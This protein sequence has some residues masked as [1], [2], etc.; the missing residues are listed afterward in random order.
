[1]TSGSRHVVSGA[2]SALAWSRYAARAAAAELG[3][4]AETAAQQ[5]WLEHL[6]AQPWDAPRIADA[7]QRERTDAATELAAQTEEQVL[8]RA[9]RRVR[10]HVLL[11][12]IAR[13]LD[14]RASL[15]EV[16]RAMT[17]L[18]ETAVQE[19]LAVLA[20]ALAQR[21]GVPRAPD[22]TPQDLLVVAMGKGGGVELNVSSDLDLVFVYDEEGD[23]DAAGAAKSI[24]NHEFFERLGRALIA[25]LSE[26]TAD[27]FV[28]RVDMRLRPNGDSG[29][30]AVSTAM[31]EEYFIGQGRE[32][33]RFAWLKGRVIS[34]PVFASR[35]QF[36]AQLHSLETEVRP[37]VYRKYLDFGAIA[38]L[39]DL[40]A[41][42][43][44]E[45]GRKNL[46]RDG[47][48]DQH[49][50]NVK[51]GR[52]GIREIEFI[53]Q[54]FQIIRGGRERRL[55]SR[56]TLQTLDV[57]QDLG[58]LAAE[59]CA[60]LAQAYEFLRRL[61]HALQY[62]DDMQTHLLPADAAERER[63]ARMLRLSSAAELTQRFEATRDFVATTFDGVFVDPGTSLLT[64]GRPAVALD[65]A[66]LTERLAELG[67]A[68][69][70]QSAE[71]IQALLAAR[72]VVGSGASRNA[73]QRLVARALEAVAAAAHRPGAGAYA[74]AECSAD[75]LLARFIRLLDVL[76]GRTTY[77]ALLAQ[78]PQAFARVLR[79]L[80]ASRWATEYLLRH[81]ILLDEL[82]D[83][84][85][86]DITNEQRV[87][88]SEWRA[89]LETQLAA[90]H[91]DS[92]REM[93]LVR[94]AHHAQVFRLLVADLDGRLTV[95][96]LADHLSLLADVVL[97]VVLRLIWRALPRRHR[98]APRFA[99]VAY[100]KLG[101]KELGYASDLDLIFLFDDEHPDAAE[102]YALFARKLTIWLTT[103]TSSGILFSV[104]LRL[105]PNGD[106]G[107]LVS[108][109]AAFERYERNDDGHGAWTWEHQALTR[110]RFCAGDVQLGA[111]FEA[112]RN[113]V[114]ARPRDLGRLRQEVIEMRRK[115][116]DGHPNRG[117]L[118]DL[119]HDRGGMVDI[120]FI[121]QFLV[122]AHAHGQPRLLGNLGNIALLN[123]AGELGLIDRALAS[124]VANAYR[125][126]RRIQHRLRLNVEPESPA[127]SKVPAEEMT[128][129]MTA[130]ITAV[131][132]LWRAVF[133]TDAPQ[134]AARR[135]A[136]A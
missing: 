112:L 64:A 93:N 108:S 20:P 47:G 34:A 107:L 5:A 92:E 25:L 89:E 85:L 8:A 50:N 114:L 122:L 65:G 30:L 2:H 26:L 97:D 110:A 118:F 54:T 22:G 32:W 39:R 96:R 106:A 76:A 123:I 70:A 27:G 3:A 75:E 61:E 68:A 49:E 38:A 56:S 7:L 59:T 66:A 126:Y 60:R 51:L 86:T 23:T 104:D 13:D 124:T 77:L 90:L 45:T 58:L 14:G 29:P 46:R 10:R 33:E 36:D 4:H 88:W 121:V 79:L 67:Y 133:D 113:E 117:P 28:F 134:R 120:E 1:M 94:D 95:E 135:A 91:G 48:H 78:Y 53:A 37:F 100:G 72:R 132:T 42:I 81:P 24:S 41:L 129:E 44:A 31:L 111:Q 62:V 101:G 103:H 15:D 128:D 9:L 40:H 125:D 109:R 12:L 83:D 6:A 18:A 127:G 115:M 16:M 52:G 35:T 21:Y 55:T 130:R 136:A 99:V 74:A 116:L 82:L 131:Q 11:A 105:R 80:A 57:L 43:R 19:G 87:D 17:A 84:R 102:V 69:P 73:V 63:I 119:K 98:D 71:R